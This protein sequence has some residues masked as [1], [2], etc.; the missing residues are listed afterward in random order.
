MIVLVIGGT[1]SGKSEIAEQLARR[2]G[3]PVTVVVPGL[4]GDDDFSAR[5]A[6]H[7]ARRPPEW[8]T[9]ECAAQLAG[10]LHAAP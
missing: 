3:E 8:A 1:R 10:A 9:V 6:E 5:V 4:V 7:R 2:L